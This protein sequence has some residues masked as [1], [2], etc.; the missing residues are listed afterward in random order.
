MSYQDNPAD[1]YLDKRKNITLFCLGCKAAGSFLLAIGA[2][3]AIV[4]IIFVLK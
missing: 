1:Q 2:I 3:A 4:A